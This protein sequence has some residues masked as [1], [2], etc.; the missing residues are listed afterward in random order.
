MSVERLQGLQ[1]PL[2]QSELAAETHADPQWRQA[3]QGKK[4]QS[5]SSRWLP[6]WIVLINVAVSTV[7]GGR[8]QRHLRFT[9]RVGASRPHTLQLPEFLQGVQSGQAEGGVSVQGRPEQEEETE[10]QTQALPSY[11][12]RKHI[13]GSF[14]LVLDF[15]QVF[16]FISSPTS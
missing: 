2:H 9:G 14:S 8:L 13:L 5:C 6:S 16:S 11:V 3:L 12:L 15:I 1:H 10:E 7:R 4:V